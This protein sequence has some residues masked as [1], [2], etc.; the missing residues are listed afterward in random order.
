M[1]NISNIYSNGKNSLRYSQIISEL[2]LNQTLTIVINGTYDNRIDIY[3]NVSNV[4]YIKCES[5]NIGDWLKLH[6]N[7]TCLID[8]CNNYD[9]KNNTNNITMVNETLAFITTTSGTYPDISATNVMINIDDKS[10]GNTFLSNMEAFGTISSIV[11]F[12]LAVLLAMA[13]IIIHK[14]VDLDTKGTDS[15]KLQYIFHFAFNM[16]DF[17][18]DIIFCTI[19]YYNDSNNEN[20]D[21]LFVWSVVFTL[22]PYLLSLVICCYFVVKWRKKNEI[23][24]ESYLFDYELILFGA[25]SVAGFYN[26]IALFQSKIFYKKLFYFSLKNNELEII[27]HFGF[28][29]VVFCENVPQLVIQY[30][31]LYFNG[32]NGNASYFVFIAMSFS[33][34]SIITSI[35]QELSNICTF[36]NVKN[37]SS[38]LKHNCIVNGRLRIDCIQLNEYH[39]FCIQSMKSSIDF[40]IQNGNGLSSFQ[41]RLLNK[42]MSYNIEVYNIIGNHTNAMNKSDR[43]IIVEFEILLL[44]KNTIDDKI[45]DTFI[46]VLQLMG[47]NHTDQYILLRKVSLL[48]LL[49]KNLI[50]QYSNI[51]CFFVS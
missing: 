24:F 14:K 32:S 25:T 29:N 18:S 7:G 23:R 33:V 38:L 28:V 40:F 43:Y 20:I 46:N 19:L 42:D 12:T 47:Q 6:C 35:L 21:K 27:K 8:G 36:C 11:I 39:Q 51:I 17:W 44:S 50:V 41:T 16:S 30:L 2:G 13:A 34:I 37:K 31:Y 15:P 45:L 3:C 1:R 9:D 49:L 22:F 26:S 4:C 48:C 5:G 10:D